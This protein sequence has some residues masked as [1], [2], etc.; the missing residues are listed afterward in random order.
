MEEKIEFILDLIEL[1]NHNLKDQRISI[2]RE[3][4]AYNP[5]FYSLLESLIAHFLDK[6]QIPY[7]LIEEKWVERK[8]KFNSPLAE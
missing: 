6:Y 7:G 1:K 4:V 2:Q 8:I 3:M 5:V